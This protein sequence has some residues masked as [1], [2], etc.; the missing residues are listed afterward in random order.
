MCSITAYNSKSKN[1]RFKIASELGL[2]VS[3][4]FLKS[5]ELKD[6]FYLSSLP[7]ANNAILG[8]GKDWK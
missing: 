8:N 7:D 3:S 2:M 4:L 1:S 5:H 6:K